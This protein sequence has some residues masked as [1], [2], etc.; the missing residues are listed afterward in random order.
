MV[1]SVEYVQTEWLEMEPFM[2]AEVLGAF[3]FRLPLHALAK[4]RLMK[5]FISSDVRI[6]RVILL[7]HAWIILENIGV[8]LVLL[9]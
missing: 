4:L 1:R 6:N 5:V 8:V 7:W 9:A 2:A 3:I